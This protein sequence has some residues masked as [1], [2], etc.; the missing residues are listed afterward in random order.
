MAKSSPMSKRVLATN[1]GASMAAHLVNLAVQLWVVSYLLNRIPAEEFQLWPIVQGLAMFL[2]ILNT[3]LTAG[4]GRYVNEAYAQGD[5][6]RITEI[7][8]TM[9]FPCLGVGVALG[10]LVLFLAWQADSVLDLPEGR[11]WEAQLM[12]L[13][14][15]GP[16]PL[17]I[18]TAPFK[19][20]LYVRQKFVLDGAIKSGGV[21]LRAALLLIL[22]LSLSP[23]VLWVAVASTSAGL[24]QQSLIFFL[25]RRLV[26]ELRFSLS[27]LNWQPA[28]E[29]MGFGV[30]ATVSRL[31]GALRMAAD[32]II[33][34]R[35]AGAVAVNSFH[36]GLMVD[37]N[38]QTLLQRAQFPLVPVLTTMHATGERGRLA[39][40]FMRST[41][42]LLWLSLLAATPLV[43]FRNELLAVYLGPALEKYP[44]AP[45]LMAILLLTYPSLFSTDALRRVGMATAKLKSLSIRL[46]GSQVIGVVLAVVLAG[47]MQHGA[48]GVAVAALIARGAVLPTLLMPLVPTL[49]GMTLR[50]FLLEAVAP[51]VGP[52]IVVGVVFELI[53]R[54]LLPDGAAWWLIALAGTILLQMLVI[55]LVMSP[56]DRKDLQSI[57]DRLRKMLRLR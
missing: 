53:R 3:I 35:L 1:S 31:G 54:F 55:R 24:L 4:L 44:E 51:G 20:G 30:W 37:R 18:C 40:A 21:L 56:A 10:L 23:R 52:A 42:L 16:M 13:I 48:M 6:R 25:S 26:P 22:L 19:V 29:I 49:T 2:P 45:A 9:F 33:L 50:R 11:V 8:S 27:H 14:L 43:V 36:V 41:R 7:T 34:N 38:A 57:T 47:P 17:T 28:R 12:I 15:L 32:P 5:G 39:N 46:L